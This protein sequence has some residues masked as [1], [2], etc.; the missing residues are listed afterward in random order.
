MMIEKLIKSLDS[1]KQ[2]ITVI[3]HDVGHGN[4]NEIKFG[5]SRIFFD[6]GAQKDWTENKIQK[7]IDN[8]NIKLGENIYIFISHWDVDHYHAILKLSLSQ[9]KQIR[10]FVSPEKRPLTNTAKRVEDLLKR[11]GIP[12]F[13]I[14][15]SNKVFNDRRV[16]LQLKYA[17]NT[18]K[19]FRSTKTNSRNLDSIVFLLMRD[20]N[21]VVFTGD[22]KYE[23]LYE[24]VMVPST[25]TSSLIFV[26]PHHGGNAGDLKFHDWSR[27][28]IGE[29]VVSYHDTNR[30]GH[31]LDIN[32]TKARD[33]I[34]PKSVKITNGTGN[35]I[36]TI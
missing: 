2:E 10:G 22:Q 36:F 20:K 16:E 6:I 11:E 8:V 18:L 13:S 12:I 17:G 27:I 7:I 1:F 21:N 28:S 35:K 3:I 14:P 29:V 34:N 30:Y 15:F 4:W 23:K 32:M 19:I 26:L 9:L 5:K 25:P 33:L 24:Y 31:P